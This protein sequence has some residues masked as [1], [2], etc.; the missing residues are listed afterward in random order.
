MFLPEMVLQRQYGPLETV[1]GYL[2]IEKH[3]YLVRYAVYP[4]LRYTALIF[5]GSKSV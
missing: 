3:M 4:I 2:T 5:S 1:F